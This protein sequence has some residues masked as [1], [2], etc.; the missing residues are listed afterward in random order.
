[1]CKT[2]GV[3]KGVVQRNNKSQMTVSRKKPP[4]HKPSAAMEAALDAVAN[5]ARDQE[6]LTEL[7]AMSFQQ[8][9]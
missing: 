2:P 5:M 8:S 1:M 9:L 7:L 4:A 6:S 3:R